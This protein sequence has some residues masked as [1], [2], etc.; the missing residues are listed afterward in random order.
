MNDTL[1]TVAGLRRHVTDRAL[2]AL[3]AL[4]APDAV[5]DLAPPPSPQMGD[6]GFPCFALAKILRQAPPRIAAAVAERIAPDE[7]I[8]SVGTDKAYV[9]IRLRRE[10]LISVVVGQALREGD[11][12]GAAQADPPRHWMVEY[13]APNTNKP[14]HLGHLRNNVLGSSVCAILEH[15][16]H[17]VTR[18]NLVNDRGVHICKSMLAYQRWGAETDPERAGKKGDHLVG[19]FYVL[20]DRKLSEEYAAWQ[21]TEAAR[22]GLAAW[23][24]QPAGRA[25]RQAAE[26]DPE[27]PP[28]ERVFFDAHNNLYFNNE[29]PLGA[30]V[31]QLL[32]LWEEGDSATLALWRKLNDWVLAGFDASYRRMGVRFDH[33][34]YESQ[35]YKL[36][37]SIVEEGLKSGALH[38]LPD[39]AVVCDLTQVGLKGEKVLLRSDGTSVYMTQDLGTAAE[40]FDRYQIDRLVYVVGDEQLYHFD[41]LFRVLGLLRPGL[42]QACYHLAYG[43]I[44]LPEGKMKSREGTV[45]DADELMGEMHELARAETQSRVDEGKAHT[46]GISTAELEHR[47]EQIAMSAIKYFLLKFT[48]RK[49]F[50]YNPRESIDFLGQTGPY[51]LFNYARTRSLLRKAAAAPDALEP[52]FDA[53]TVARLGTERELELVRLLAA[54]PETVA[55]AADA[56]DPSRVAEYVFDLC[57]SF[58]FI[59]TDKA[60]HP[61]AT[62]EDAQLRAARLLLVAAVSHALRVGLRLLGIDA[63]EEM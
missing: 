5:V 36:G 46:D 44:R 6:L 25:A 50:E 24:E 23:L 4:G 27:A 51:C 32:R 63:L 49:S 9:N 57:K 8:E 26:Q 13:S 17:R 47:A 7:V 29:S 55:R 28:P 1:L 15:Y 3:A 2:A 42:S 39:G 58:A 59:F 22:A 20:F 19:D 60:N 43:M 35:T 34:Q 54:F 52:A 56:L 37:R 21:Q 30:E 18:I 11:R 12:F 10:A 33:V 31:R 40:R 53:A 41:V 45:V 14:L 16:G 61:I 62:C 38:R 48:P